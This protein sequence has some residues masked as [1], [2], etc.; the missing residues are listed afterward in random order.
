MGADTKIEWATHTFNAW[1]GC[2]KIA[3]GCKNCYAAA[4]AKRNPK[5]LGE[6]GPEGTRIVASEAMW[7]QPLKWNKESEKRA[8]QHDRHPEL[9][10]YIRPQVFC[11]S[12][13]D[14]FEDWKGQVR[15][16]DGGWLAI[17]P[18]GR[19][20]VNGNGERCPSGSRFATLDDVRARLFSL[21]DETPNLD[22]L[23]LTKRPEN[24]KSLWP[25]ESING[26]DFHGHRSR[27][28]VWIGTS[29][30]CQFDADRNIPELLKCRDLAPVLFLSIEPLVAPVDLVPYL[31]I[32]DPTGA[33]ADLIPRRG[34]FTPAID[35]VIVGG[36]SGPH[37]RPLPPDWVRLIRDQCQ[38]AGVAFF[39]KQWGEWMPTFHGIDPT[40]GD[41]KCRIAAVHNLGGGQ[42]MWKVGKAG[43]G[44]ML[45]GREWNELPEVQR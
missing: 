1:R 24:I 10:P 28:N 38:A 3:A 23:L 42:S 2:E 15:T 21:I 25:L 20:F 22:K 11:N 14:V 18:D 30:A 39:F 19:W 12:I 29:I 33:P 32:N 44:R 6:W 35:W 26:T 16:H 9:G 7:Q 17:N 43:A 31:F 8:A 13:A 4:F 37:A 41:P 36:E 27:K 34:N 45:D 5:M 40:K